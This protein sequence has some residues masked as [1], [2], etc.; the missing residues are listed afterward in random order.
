VFSYVGTESQNRAVN[1]LPVSTFLCIRYGMAGRSG[2][3]GIGTLKKVN[4]TGAVGTADKKVLEIRPITILERIAGRY[5]K[6]AGK[7]IQLL[8]GK[9]LLFTSGDL[10][11]K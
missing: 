9:A 4:L 11:A 5:S 8:T 1:G 2:G 10:F 3:C 7:P 6:L